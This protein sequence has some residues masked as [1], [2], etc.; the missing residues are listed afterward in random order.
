MRGKRK[1][2]KGA[3]LLASTDYDRI[4]QAYEKGGKIEVVELWQK[5]EYWFNHIEGGRERI[6]KSIFK[7]LSSINL[8]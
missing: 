6:T 2:L 4:K 1:V 3:Y 8:T 7:K 5:T